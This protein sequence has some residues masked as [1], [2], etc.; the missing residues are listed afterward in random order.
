LSRFVR[1]S[2]TLTLTDN[3]L[4]FWNQRAAMTAA[5]WQRMLADRRG[6]VEP[7]LKNFGYFHLRD[8]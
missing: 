7:H 6:M 4:K 2:G 5:D 8:R 1:C 3:Y